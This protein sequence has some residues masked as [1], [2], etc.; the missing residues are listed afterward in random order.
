VN[1]PGPDRHAAVRGPAAEE[2]L[3]RVGA[4][5]LTSVRV[6]VRVSEVGS[7]TGAAPGLGYSQPGL[8][9]RVS[10]T[11][12]SLGLRL[13]RRSSTGVTLTEIGA[14]I[15]PY[16]RVLLVVSDELAEE[17]TRAQARP[18]DRPR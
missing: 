1:G 12:Q 9:Q 11:E 17:I 7:I 15:L 4:L 16:A 5:D 18:E 10:S 2:V 6:L 3:R 13:F 14:T 8:S